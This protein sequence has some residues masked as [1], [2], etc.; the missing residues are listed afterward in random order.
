MSVL[1]QTDD[2]KKQRRS[3]LKSLFTLGAG[4]GLIAVTGGKAKA[5]ATEKVKMLTPDGKLVEIDRSQ[6]ENE[7]PERAS[8]HEVKQWMNKK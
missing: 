5:E 8:N 1:M 2:N 7:S 6:I 3:F 4:A